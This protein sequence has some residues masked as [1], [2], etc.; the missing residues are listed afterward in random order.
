MVARALEK[1]Y[2]RRDSWWFS[3]E[4]QNKVKCESK[5]GSGELYIDADRY[6]QEAD[7]SATEERYKEDNKRK[8]KKGS[9]RAKIK[10]YEDLME[11]AL[12]NEDAIRRRWKGELFLRHSSTDKG[13][14]DEDVDCIRWAEWKIGVVEGGARR[15][16]DLDLLDMIPNDGLSKK[17]P[18]A[19]IVNKMREGTIEMFGHVK[20]RPQSAP[21][22]KG[23]GLLFRWTWEAR[24]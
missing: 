15:Q 11:E 7:R 19:T 10:A 1:S 21:V 6:E 5:L 14:P 9:F 8:Q 2:G 13:V 12:S 3:E 24:G 4:V 18:V 17:S 16:G 22:K 23:G 20:R